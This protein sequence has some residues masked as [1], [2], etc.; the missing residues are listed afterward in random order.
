M[1]KIRF[2]GDVAL[3]ELKTMQGAETKSANYDRPAWHFKQQY[4]SCTWIIT[5]PGEGI[6]EASDAEFKNFVSAFDLVRSRWRTVA[7]ID[8]QQ[9]EFS[10]DA[11][12]CR[13]WVNDCYGYERRGISRVLQRAMLERLLLFAQNTRCFT[14]WLRARHH[15][16]QLQE[17]LSEIE[18]QRAPAAP[19][20]VEHLMLSLDALRKKLIDAA[21]SRSVTEVAS[22]RLSICR[23]AYVTLGHLGGFPPTVIA[24]S[25]NPEF[26]SRQAEGPETA[27]SLK[28]LLWMLDRRSVVTYI[29]DREVLTDMA[30]IARL[31]AAILHQYAKT[32]VCDVVATHTSTHVRQMQQALDEARESE[33][34]L[35]QMVLWIGF[36]GSSVTRLVSAAMA[37][38]YALSAPHHHICFTLCLCSHTD[39]HACHA[40]LACRR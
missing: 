36:E 28:E 23:L 35:H 40:C 1:P 32:A 38:G 8:H 15:T 25:G 30:L 12:D 37:L 11:S 34:D 26:E 18:H 29:D 21:S 10:I 24:E 16:L 4:E 39:G 2:A 6:V 14:A 5:T 19:Q 7:E 31:R 27:E 17:A 22:M 13:Q 33:A 20:T 3:I 9:R